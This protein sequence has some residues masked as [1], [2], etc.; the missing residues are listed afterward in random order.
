MCLAQAEFAVNS[1]HNRSTGC[2]TLVAA[3]GH[4]PK[5]VLDVNNGPSVHKKVKE[6]IEANRT[7]HKQV[8]EAIST[9]NAKCKVGA[10][11]QGEYNTF[12][13]ENWPWCTS[14]R[15]NIQKGLTP[16]SKIK[17]L[18]LARSSRRSMIMPNAYVVDLLDE[19]NMSPTFNVADL[20][21]YYPPDMED[22]QLRTIT[23]LQ[24][25]WSHLM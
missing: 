6:I 19:F 25:E 1:M 16:N 24:P 22:E 4:L 10:N 15:I 8:E 13:K 18:N 5:T 3:Y 9:A 20:R 21:K 14:E 17:K 2:A 7:V 12:W 23:N 11:K